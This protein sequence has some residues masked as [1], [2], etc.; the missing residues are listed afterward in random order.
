MNY[1]QTCTE[2]CGILLVQQLRHRFRV[3]RSLSLEE[4]E[5]FRHLYGAFF[6][7]EPENEIIFVS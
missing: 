4:L 7:L 1:L 5:S 2:E 3:G 6:A